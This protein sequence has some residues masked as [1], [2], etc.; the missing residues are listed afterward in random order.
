MLMLYEKLVL[1][2]NLLR[3]INFAVLNQYVKKL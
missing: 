2:R 3:D 1:R